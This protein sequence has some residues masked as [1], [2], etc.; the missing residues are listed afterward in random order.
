MADKTFGTTPDE[1]EF[2]VEL[3]MFRTEVEQA[4]SSSTRSS[5]STQR[6]ARMSG[7]WHS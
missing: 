5:R 3:E 2:E 1:V 4:K 7:F 6:P